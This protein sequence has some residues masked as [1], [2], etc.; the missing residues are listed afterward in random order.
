MKYLSAIRIAWELR[1]PTV[2]CLE[3]QGGK[4][5]NLE[6]PE[7]NPFDFTSQSSNL[8]LK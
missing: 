2:W 8:V 7:G 3:D 5:D 1:W 4:S 6:N